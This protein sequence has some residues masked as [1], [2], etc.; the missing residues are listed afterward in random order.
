MLSE[1]IEGSLG[2][3]K[4]AGGISQVLVCGDLVSSKTREEVHGEK[5]AKPT[6][7]GEG[8]THAETKK[9]GANCPKP[10]FRRFP[11]PINP[12][13]LFCKKLKSGF[14]V[15][16]FFTHTST[17]LE[18]KLLKTISFA[19]EEMSVAQGAGQSSYEVLKASG[20]AHVAA[21]GIR[22]GAEESYVLDSHEE[23]TGHK[24]LVRTNPDKIQLR[25]PGWAA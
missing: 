8:G 12:F 20:G 4:R 21:A 5:G 24:L 1:Y 9:V 25:I 19:A 11:S 13:L 17:D 3:E 23:K 6:T 10:C 14:T 18:M 16:A 15:S 22:T 2:D 7:N